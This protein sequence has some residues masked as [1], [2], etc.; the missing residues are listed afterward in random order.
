[1]SVTAMR[2]E[3]REEPKNTDVA[4]GGETVIACKPPR[5]KPEPRVRWKKDSEV[6]KVGD[7]FV[8]DESGNLKVRD[9]R[10]EDSGMYICVA[11]NTGGEKDSLAA[12]LSVRGMSNSSRLDYCNTIIQ[13]L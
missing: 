3:F 6:L 11:Y 1:M 9:A 8:L 2:D 5:G 10:K 4:V 12:R 13:G 7:R